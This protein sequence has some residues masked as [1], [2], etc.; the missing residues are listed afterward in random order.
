MKIKESIYNGE[1]SWLDS[2]ASIMYHEINDN[3]LQT[4][5]GINSKLDKTKHNI[6]RMINMMQ[7]EKVFLIT[8]LRKLKSNIPKASRDYSEKMLNPHLHTC[9]VIMKSSISRI[10]GNLLFSFNKKG[11]VKIKLFSDLDSALAWSRE[12]ALEFS[13]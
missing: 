10:F 5:E 12:Q 11:S 13:R 3:G 4:L 9:A 7:D 2:E 6:G 8:D 1:I